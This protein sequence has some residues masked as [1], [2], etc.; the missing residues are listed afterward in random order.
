MVLSLQGVDSNAVRGMQ[1]FISE[2]AWDDAPILK[3]HWQEVDKDLGE[4]D[5]I[6]MLDESDFLKQGSESVGVK[7]QS[8]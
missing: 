6:L 8:R 4:Q 3:Q 7:R 1:Q 5:G 2:G